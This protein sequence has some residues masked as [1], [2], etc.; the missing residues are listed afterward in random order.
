GIVLTADVGAV[1]RV[2]VVDG[3]GL[4]VVGAKVAVSAPKQPPQPGQARRQIRVD[5]GDNEVHISGDGP[6]QYGS[7]T[8]DAGGHVEIQGLPAG[9]A[10]IT[11]AH[12][13]LAEPRPADVVLPGSG[14]VDARLTMR[15]PGFAAITVTTPDGAPAAAS[16]RVHGP[17]GVRDDERD[18]PAKAGA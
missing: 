11:A 17:L 9:A 12:E 4:P 15:E 5:R 2:D 18:R 13:A 6:E 14:F 8:T 10:V 7:G 1:A 3:K 16:L